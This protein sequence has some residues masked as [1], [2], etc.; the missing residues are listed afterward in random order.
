MKQNEKQRPSMEIR[1]T[2]ATVFFVFEGKNGLMNK[3]KS[4]RKWYGFSNS[5]GIDYPK[6][7]LKLM[8]SAPSSSLQ[9]KTLKDFFCF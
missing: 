6:T 9:I 8:A 2:Q 7:I 4:H 1:K 5:H 3:A